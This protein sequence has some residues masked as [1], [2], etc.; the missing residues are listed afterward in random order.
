MQAYHQ[1][2]LRRTPFGDLPAPSESRY[3]RPD[4]VSPDRSQE[5]APA[6]YEIFSL[7][8]AIGRLGSGTATGQPAKN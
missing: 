6:P 2:R 1:P 7:R 8:P 4:F 5:S 3:L